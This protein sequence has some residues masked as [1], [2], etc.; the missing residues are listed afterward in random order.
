MMV[1]AAGGRVQWAACAAGQGGSAIWLWCRRRTPLDT[2]AAE[3]E[4]GCTLVVARGGREGRQGRCVDLKVR[5]RGRGRRCVD[6]GGAGSLRGHP[7]GAGRADEA[8]SARA[9][10]RPQ[11][12]RAFLGRTK[13]KSHTY[14]H[15]H[16]GVPILAQPLRP[17]LLPSPQLNNQVSVHVAPTSRGT[18]AGS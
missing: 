15:T 7:L 13:D 3:E 16:P 18:R 17:G 11:G 9:Q 2:R 8:W 6:T 4:R 1:A 12:G 14:T 10:G 5:G